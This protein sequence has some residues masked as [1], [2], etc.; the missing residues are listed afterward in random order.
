MDEWRYVVFN[1]PVDLLSCENHTRRD[2]QLVDHARR[3]SDRSPAELFTSCKVLYLCSFQDLGMISR[4]S[5]LNL[6]VTC[7]F[8][9]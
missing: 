5:A 9:C 7:V 3:Q 1:F 4:A 6:L 8:A 2:F